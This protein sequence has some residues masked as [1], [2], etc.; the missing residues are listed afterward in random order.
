MNFQGCFFIY[1]S[2][3]LQ[4]KEL[5]KNSQLFYSKLFFV[6]SRDE[7]IK[8]EI[9]VERTAACFGMKLNAERRNVRVFDSLASAVVRV[10]ETQIRAARQTF[11]VHCIAVILA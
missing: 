9:R 3:F 1:V 7:F 2:Q 11:V 4:A 8:Q 6:N 5:Q 10:Y